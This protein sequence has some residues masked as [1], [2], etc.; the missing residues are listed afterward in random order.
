VASWGPFSWAG[1]WVW[2][3]KDHIDQKFVARYQFN[4]TQP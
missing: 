4:E 3:W 1:N 2:Q